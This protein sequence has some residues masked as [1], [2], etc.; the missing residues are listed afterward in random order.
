MITAM[1]GEATVSKVLK[2]LEKAELNIGY[3]NLTHSA[4]VYFGSDCIMG[5]EIRM[6]I[7]DKFLKA[8]VLVLNG[9]GDVTPGT[10]EI[11]KKLMTDRIIYGTK[12]PKVK[13]VVV[14]FHEDPQDA[15]KKLARLTKTVKVNA[16]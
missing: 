4:G 5:E 8:D 13:S 10:L 1:P 9:G 14:I 2:V 6:K 12:L 3:L 15:A 16:H 11:I 7:S